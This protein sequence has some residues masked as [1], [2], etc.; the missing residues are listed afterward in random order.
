MRCV[1]KVSMQR[2]GHGQR[3]RNSR[4]TTSL[5]NNAA[6]HIST[7]GNLLAASRHRYSEKAPGSRYSTARREKYLCARAYGIL[8]TIVSRSASLVKL[9]T[10]RSAACTGEGPDDEKVRSRR[11][12]EPCCLLKIGKTSS[13]AQSKAIRFAAA[14]KLA[15]K[16]KSLRSPPAPGFSF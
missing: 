12:E 4:L 9:R 7:G 11:A 14:R 16:L 13:T 15:P 8:M 5:R 6:P 2:R 3:M 1:V 10:D